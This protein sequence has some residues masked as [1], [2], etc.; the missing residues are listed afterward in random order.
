MEPVE[1]WRVEESQVEE[2]AACSDDGDEKLLRPSEGDD[3]ESQVVVPLERAKRPRIDSDTEEEEDEVSSS[4]AAVSANLTS[5]HN[6]AGLVKNRGDSPVPTSEPGELQAEESQRM[7]FEEN[8]KLGNLRFQ[9]LAQSAVS[10]MPTSG[11]H[12]SADAAHPETLNVPAPGPQTNVSTTVPTFPTAAVEGNDSLD[13]PEPLL[14]MVE[15]RVYHRVSLCLL[16]SLIMLYQAK[17]AMVKN[18]LPPH[19]KSP[20]SPSKRMA[21]LYTER[22]RE[23]AIENFK[24][25][26]S[27]ARFEARRALICAEREVEAAQRKVES[28]KKEIEGL[29]AEREVVVKWYPGA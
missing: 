9:D 4:G 7:G 1:E 2:P 20:E 16:H 27:E 22:E 14:K 26:T 6:G 5:K 29:D 17:I 24:R 10:A 23:R 21:K 18:N 25:A 3:K 28:A 15:V 19:P 13:S 11:Y 12:P 8:A